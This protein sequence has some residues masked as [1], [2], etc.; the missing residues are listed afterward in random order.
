MLFY[1]TIVTNVLQTDYS[2]V[3]NAYFLVFYS[4]SLVTAIVRS[5]EVNADNAYA[6]VVS[7]PDA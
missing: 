3:T 2:F 5:A 6:T 7:V 1:N 4:L